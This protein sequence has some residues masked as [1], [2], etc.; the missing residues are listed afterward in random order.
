MCYYELCLFVVS[1]LFIFCFQWPGAPTL[2][3]FG[4]GGG[5]RLKS[6]I[7]GSVSIESVAVFKDAPDQW[8]NPVPLYLRWSLNEAL[9]LKRVFWQSKFILISE[10]KG[11][12]G[13]T[14][15]L[16]H[17]NTA[18]F[19]QTWNQLLWKP[20]KPSVQ[21]YLVET[22][23]L[24]FKLFLLNSDVSFHF[25]HPTFCILTLPLSFHFSVK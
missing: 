16:S 17:S 1:I 4:C 14:V 23:Q 10:A 11:K 15:F 13:E 5:E 12:W 3:S 19:L 8:N 18:P 22:I 9:C 2:K 25:K 24:L 6:E 21:N 20:E 7:L